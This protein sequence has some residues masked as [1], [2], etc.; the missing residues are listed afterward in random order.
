MYGLSLSAPMTF[1]AESVAPAPTSE[2]GFEAG[3]GTA[4][5]A[6]SA[7]AFFLRALLDSTDAAGWGFAISEAMSRRFFLTRIGNGAKGCTRCTKAKIRLE[8]VGGL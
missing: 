1:P 5:V 8:C 2:A 3:A 4:A 7:L 6:A